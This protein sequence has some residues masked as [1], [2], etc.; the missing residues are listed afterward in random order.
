[1]QDNIGL[2]EIG[3]CSSNLLP[4]VLVHILFQHNQSCS[5]EVSQHKQQ[6]ASHLIGNFFDGAWLMHTGGAFDGRPADFAL[7]KLLFYECH[8]C[9]RPYYGGQRQCGADGGSPD[10][11]CPAL[12]CITISILVPAMLRTVQ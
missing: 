9:S 12:P 8:K 4:Q 1:M 6:H 5:F 2:S 7:T 3:G 11:P 10:V